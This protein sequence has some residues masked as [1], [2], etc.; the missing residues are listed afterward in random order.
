[1]VPLSPT[2][3]ARVLYIRI[4]DLSW[5]LFRVG[6]IVYVNTATGAHA[7]Y[8]FGPFAVLF[9]ICLEFS[10]RTKLLPNRRMTDHTI[11]RR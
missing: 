7:E 1:M 5:Q 2:T 11:G 8:L 6:A 4:L 9:E 3:L 10:E